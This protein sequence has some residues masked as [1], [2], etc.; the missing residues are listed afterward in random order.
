MQHQQRHRRK[1][2][3]P[4]QQGQQAQGGPGRS[5]K[6]RAVTPAEPPPR[7]YMIDATFVGGVARF[8]NHS[9]DPNCQVVKVGMWCV[10]VCFEIRQGM[11]SIGMAPGLWHACVRLCALPKTT[12]TFEPLHN[13]TMT[14]LS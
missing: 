8:A 7:T 12:S 14:V 3:Q 1:Q 6:V 10:F 2:K 9:C 11:I 4:Q 5:A 13:T